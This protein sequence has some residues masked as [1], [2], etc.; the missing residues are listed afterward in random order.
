MHDVRRP[1]KGRDLP[2]RSLH[3]TAPGVPT[4]ADSRAANCD[5]D[6]LY[7]GLNRGFRD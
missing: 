7:Q 4:G 2:I 5:L 3:D 6:K 1:R